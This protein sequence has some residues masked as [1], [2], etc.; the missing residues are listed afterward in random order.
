MGA[1]QSSGAHGGDDSGVGG[2]KSTQEVKTCY[3]GLLNL[4]RQAS[5]DE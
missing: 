3:Y 4:D 5:D 2:R 1:N